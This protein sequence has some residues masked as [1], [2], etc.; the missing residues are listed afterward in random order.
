LTSWLSGTLRASWSDKNSI[1]GDFN[2]FNAHSG[3]MDFPANQGG[4]FFDIGIGI[5][6]SLAGNDIALEWLEP[7]SNNFEGVQLD[8]KGVLAARWGYGF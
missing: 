2:T 3:P 6:A 5:T 1:D 7:V 8:R 4:R